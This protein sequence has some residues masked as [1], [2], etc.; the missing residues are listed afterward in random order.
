MHAAMQ[1][2]TRITLLAMTCWIRARYVLAVKGQSP[3]LAAPGLQPGVHEPAAGHAPP[4]IVLHEPPAHTP[5]MSR[6]RGVR[7][8]VHQSDRQ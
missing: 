8:D 3:P 4:H 6:Q 1:L 7:L 2:S 5:N